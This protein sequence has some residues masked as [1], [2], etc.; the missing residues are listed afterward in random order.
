MSSDLGE[1]ANKS[2]VTLKCESNNT[3]TARDEFSI[4]VKESAGVSGVRLFKHAST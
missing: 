2:R 3:N 1:V 4:N